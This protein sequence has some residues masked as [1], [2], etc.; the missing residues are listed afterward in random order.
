M[1]KIEL[2][3]QRG[4]QVTRVGGN[5]SWR[6]PRPSTARERKFTETD[7]SFCGFLVSVGGAEAGGARGARGC[8]RS[9]ADF[10]KLRFG[11]AV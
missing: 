9:R 10:R 3:L 8:A 2:Y 1:C 4:H 11:V 5:Q 7:L 6:A